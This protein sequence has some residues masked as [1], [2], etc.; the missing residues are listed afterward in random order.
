MKSKNP[1]YEAGGVITEADGSAVTL[2]LRLTAGITTASALRTLCDVTEQFD[3]LSGECQ[4]TQTVRLRH[5]RYEGRM[6][7]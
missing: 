3:G 4:I 1:I 7:L 2:R 5:I 6:Q